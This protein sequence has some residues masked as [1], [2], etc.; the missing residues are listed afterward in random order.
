[1]DVSESK[2]GI[3]RKKELMCSN[4]RRANG[5]EQLEMM[6][7]INSK[8]ELYKLEICDGGIYFPDRPV[9]ACLE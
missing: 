9:I 6:L 8:G 3:F 2:K 1:M 5:V 4:F 7:F